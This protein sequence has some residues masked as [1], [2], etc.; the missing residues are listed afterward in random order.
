MNYF[1]AV[2]KENI[3]KTYKIFIDGV[4]KGVWELKN[5]FSTE[6]FDFYRDGEP[7]TEI[8]FSSQLI[9]VRFKEVVDWSKVPVDTKVLVSND[10]KEW[11]RRHFAEY[12]DGKV[13]C[14]NSGVTS[15]TV[16]ESYFLN[17]KASWDYAKLYQ[18]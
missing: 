14:F 17:E 11:S 4:N 3:G 18:E 6:E 5:G 10:G 2:K 16:K 9:R 12:K 8:Y 15:F 1:D 7:L 13:Y